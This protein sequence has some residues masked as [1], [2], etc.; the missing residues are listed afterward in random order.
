MKNHKVGGKPVCC[1]ISRETRRGRCGEEDGCFQEDQPCL[2]AKV[3][4]RWEKG[5]LPLRDRDDHII[6][7][8]TTVKKDFD[9]L[10]KKK[11]PSEEMR[12]EA[13]NRLKMKTV[14]LAPTDWRTRIMS[15]HVLWARAKADKVNLLEDYIG[16]TATR[17]ALVTPESD[18]CIAARQR[19]EEVQREKAVAEEAREARTKAREEIQSQQ[20][21]DFSSSSQHGESSQ[22]SQSEVH[23]QEQ[24]QRARDNRKAYKKR[25]R[26]QGGDD[27]D[28]DDETVECWAPKDILRKLGHLCDKI[29]VTIRQQHSIVVSIESGVTKG[30]QKKLPILYTMIS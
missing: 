20:R 5:R 7:I 25:K 13:I 23:L 8:M 30:V 29:G 3:K 21:V 10:R 24:A 14:N 22:D 15:D 1:T 4:E 16:L 9:K 17:S 12:Q 6:D 26:M 28:D 27:D 2:L 19:A 18:H 11:F